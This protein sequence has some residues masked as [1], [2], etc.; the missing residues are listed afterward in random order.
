[1]KKHDFLP[2]A[3][4]ALVVLF[5]GC[6]LFRRTASPASASAQPSSSSSESGGAPASTPPASSSEDPASGHAVTP[7]EPAQSQPGRVLEITT[8]SGEFNEKFAGNPIDKA[9]IE[10]SDKAVSTIEMVKVSEKYAGLWQKEIIHAWEKLEQQMDMDSSG[11]PAKLEAEQ[12]NWEDGRAAALKKIS[13]EALAA[14]GSMAQV[15]EAGAVMDFY[16]GRAAQLYRELYE[17]DKSFSYAFS[18][19]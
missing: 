3:L 8:D 18:A 2:A 15:N 9:Y 10:E 17:Y 6:S 19:K 7:N 5:S 4:I 16:R 11:K 12:K 1:M 13:E 14:G